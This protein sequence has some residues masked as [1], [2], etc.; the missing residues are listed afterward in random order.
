M[1]RTEGI[2]RSVETPHIK[3]LPSNDDESIA[4]CAT[5]NTNKKCSEHPEGHVLIR[6]DRDARYEPPSYPSLE[7]Y[8]R[9]A[10]A[11]P[12]IVTV[13]SASSTASTS[14]PAPTQKSPTSP[15][16]A[17]QKPG[18][19]ARLKEKIVEFLRRVISCLC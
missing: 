5:C 10:G 4:E 18:C 1:T 3:P 8:M 16:A 2:G 6:M 15:P 13:F 11:P 7:E 9:K 17:P 14:L 19:L 12:Q